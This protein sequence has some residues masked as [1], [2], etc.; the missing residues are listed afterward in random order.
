MVRRGQDPIFKGQGFKCTGTEVGYPGG[1]WFDPFDFA[2][3]DQARRVLLAHHGSRAVSHVFHAL[4]SVLHLSPATAAPHVFRG[5]AVSIASL[6]CNLHRRFGSDSRA[7]SSFRPQ[8]KV[9]KQKEILN[10]RLAMISMLGYWSQ[11]FVTG[12]VSITSQTLRASEEWS[13]RGGTKIRSIPPPPRTPTA[14]GHT[15]LHSS[16]RARSRTSPRMSRTLRTTLSSRA[17]VF[18][19]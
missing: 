12:T 13:L 16:R 9:N 5:P 2:S 6:P 1:K 4:P 3:S 11:A 7:P 8:F 19:S 10:G 14:L 15:R 17:L 18:R